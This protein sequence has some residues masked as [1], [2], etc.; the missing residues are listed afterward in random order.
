MLDD[1][2]TKGYLVKEYPKKKVRANTSTDTHIVYDRIPDETKPKGYNIVTG[3][4]SFQYSRILCP[5]SA[6]PTLVAMDISTIGVLDSGGLRNL[7]LD[8]GLRLFGYPPSYSLDVF[9]IT[10][11]GIKKGFDLLG[12]TV[13]V[14]VI[15]AIS[16]RL[17][18]NYKTNKG[19]NQS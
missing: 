12:N 17:A 10:K 1:L 15:K 18:Q 16:E 2:E 7:T 11:E 8:E 5:Y 9:S 4:L 14:P 19:G 13:C 6:T 3:K